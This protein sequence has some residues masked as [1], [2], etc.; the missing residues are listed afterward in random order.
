[1]IKATVQMKDGRTMVILGLTA[2]NIDLLMAA[3]PIRV[4]LADLG[5]PTGP[6]VA[7]IA[8]RTDV[9]LLRDLEPFIG[10][11]TVIATEPGRP[12]ASPGDDPIP[13]DTPTSANG[14]EQHRS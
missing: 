7:I 6:V 14:T 3:A 2:T 10:P 12:S 5:M 8:A 1:M 4:D 13:T 11:N 9:G